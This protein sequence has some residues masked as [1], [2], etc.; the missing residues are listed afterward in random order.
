MVYS[1]QDAAYDEDVSFKSLS[2]RLSG[3]H[4]IVLY[5]QPTTSSGRLR[6]LEFY[7]QL[8]INYSNER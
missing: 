1:L 5:I 6:E 2:A 3:S 8:K 7:L 4:A